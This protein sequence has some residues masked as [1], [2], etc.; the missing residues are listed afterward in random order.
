[1]VERKTH[2]TALASY[3]EIQFVVIKEDYGK[4]VSVINL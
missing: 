1:M 3:V 4:Y 2:P